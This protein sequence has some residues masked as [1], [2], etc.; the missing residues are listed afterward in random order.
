MSHAEFVHLHNHT[1][2]SL[3]HAPVRIT[4]DK[5]NPSEGLKA[6]AAMKFPA[7]A[8]TDA[9]N[10]YG[11]VEF[12]SAC[13]ELGMKPIIGINAFTFKQNITI[14]TAWMWFSLTVARDFPK[15]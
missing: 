14:K 6:L 9:G 15:K 12:Y 8:I 7:L 10:M 4:D 13:M 2:Y 3:L 11:A 5:G 1:E